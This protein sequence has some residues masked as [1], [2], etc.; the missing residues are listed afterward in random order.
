MAIRLQHGRAGAVGR[1]DVFADQADSQAGVTA[2]CRI[3]PIARVNPARLH[4]ALIRVKAASRIAFQRLA[5]P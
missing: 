3:S 4:S 5:S 1:A 2:I